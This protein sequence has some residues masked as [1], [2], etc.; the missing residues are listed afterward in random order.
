MERSLVKHMGQLQFYLH[1]FSAVIAL[2]KIIE[3]LN[4]TTKVETILG[5]LN[6]ETE[7]CFHFLVAR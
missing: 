6:Y 1:H 5:Q 4:P 3:Q 2:C 7:L